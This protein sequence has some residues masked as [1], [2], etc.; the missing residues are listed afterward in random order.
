MAVT[1]TAERNICHIRM[2]QSVA[3]V[4]A[5]AL[6]LVGC[7][8]GIIQD[9]PER[10]LTAHR[11][12]DNTVSCIKGA[13]DANGRSGS[14]YT[15]VVQAITPGQSYEIRPRQTLTDYYFVRVF[16]VSDGTSKI[17][18]YA[19]PQWKRPILAAVGRCAG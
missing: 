18:V 16:K 2:P 13:L 5:T 8:H 4:V 12:L 7:A 14:G 15:H 9:P 19:V 6:L 10:L 17:D 3:I 1:K 11:S